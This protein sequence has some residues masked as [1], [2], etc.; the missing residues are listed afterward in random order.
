MFIQWIERNDSAIHS[1]KIFI[2]LFRNVFLFVQGEWLLLMLDTIWVED[3]AHYVKVSSCILTYNHVTIL[4]FSNRE[5]HPT[6]LCTPPAVFVLSLVKPPRI[7]QSQSWVGCLKGDFLENI[8]FAV[9]ETLA[10]YRIV[11]SNKDWSYMLEKKNPLYACDDLI[12][13]YSLLHWAS[14]GYSICFRVLDLV[15]NIFLSS[16]LIHIGMCNHHSFV[17]P[18]LFFGTFFS[19]K[20]IQCGCQVTFRWCDRVYNRVCLGPEISIGGT[21]Q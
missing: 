20:I 16:S 12:I 3:E 5:N 21:H 9:L 17:F 15:Q 7:H 1:L 10:Y 14:H 11:T 19:L 8:S 18:S 13:T 6:Q 4:N 2:S